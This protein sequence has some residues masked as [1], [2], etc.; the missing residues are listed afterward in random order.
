MTGFTEIEQF[1]K[2]AGEEYAKK[3]PGFKLETLSSELRGMERMGSSAAM[4]KQVK[5]F[6]SA[7]LNDASR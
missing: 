6:I 1:Y 3:N 4:M 7:F 2:K 5:Q